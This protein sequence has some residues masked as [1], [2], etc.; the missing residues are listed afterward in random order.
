MGSGAVALMLSEYPQLKPDE[1]KYWMKN[2]A[3]QLNGGS[4]SLFGSG[5]IMLGPNGGN[6]AFS[7]GPK[8]GATYSFGAVTGGGSI[9]NSRGGSHLSD[10]SAMTKDYT[11]CKWPTDSSF[12]IPP[13]QPLCGEKDVF[14]KPFSATTHAALANSDATWDDNGTVAGVKAG[15]WNGA[16]LVAPPALNAT[17]QTVGFVTD[18]TTGDLTWPSQQWIPSTNWAGSGLQWNTNWVGSRWVGSRWV[19]SRW[20]TGSWSGSRWV[21]SRWV[22]SRWVGSRW[23]GSRWVES[24]WSSA[25]WR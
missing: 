13:G 5:G 2:T 16:A 21:G 15:V 6:G 18:P 20:V 7:I 17:G 4:R 11:N 14:G 8:I 1:V 22:G 19:G 12:T 24:S 23:V 10:E 9:E 3:Q 25:G